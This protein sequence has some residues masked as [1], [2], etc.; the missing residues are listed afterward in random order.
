MLRAATCGGT[1]RGNRFA[2]IGGPALPTIAVRSFD[3]R[4]GL[5]LVAPAGARGGLFFLRDWATKPNVRLALA[6]E[7]RC[8]GAIIAFGA[9]PGIQ[10]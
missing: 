10:A 2:P 3:G 1:G 4:R 6:V 9:I 7:S 5:S 8:G